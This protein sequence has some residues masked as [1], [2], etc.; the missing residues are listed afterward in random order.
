MQ[1]GFI[2]LFPPASEP[3]LHRMLAV[4]PSRVIL[5][6][7]AGEILI[8]NIVRVPAEVEGRAIIIGVVLPGV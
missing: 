1:F 7:L 2:V 3:E 5:D 4:G 6:R 8:V